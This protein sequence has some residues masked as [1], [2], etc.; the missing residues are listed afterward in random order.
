[1]FRIKE[2]ERERGRSNLGDGELLELGLL[3]IHLERPV[4]INGLDLGHLRRRR[5][6]RKGIEGSSS[7]R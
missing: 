1:M 5:K 2:G 4:G 3:Q 7:S 6:R